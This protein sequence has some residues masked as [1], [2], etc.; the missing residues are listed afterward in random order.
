MPMFAAEPATSTPPGPHS[1]DLYA[2]PPMAEP[3]VPRETYSPP[4]MGAPAPPRDVYSPPP[5]AFP[6]SPRHPQTD[7]LATPPA[8]FPPMAP[9]K[10]P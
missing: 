6:E 2:P 3:T 7:D 1:Q 5:P 9:P 10:A 8:D 4:P